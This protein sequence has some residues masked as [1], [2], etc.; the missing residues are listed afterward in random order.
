M[1]ILHIAVFEHTR[2]ALTNGK[3]EFLLPTKGNSVLARRYLDIKR[4]LIARLESEPTTFQRTMIEFAASIQLQL[5]VLRSK[6]MSEDVEF[7]SAAETE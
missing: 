7:P 4:S 2:S 6:Q 1:S 3:R 5:E